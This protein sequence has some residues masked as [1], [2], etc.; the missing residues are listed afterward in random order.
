ME[1]LSLHILD[2]VENGTA[3]GATLVRVEIEEN[4]DED[5]LVIRI[6]D[7]G[8]GMDPEAAQQA[9]D[10][11]VTTRTTRR[12]GMGLPLLRQATEDAEGSFVIRSQ[13]GKGTHVT[14]TFQA[15][16]LDRQP[17]GDLAET[18]VTLILGNPDID[19]V[20][21]HTIDGAKTTLDTREVRE[22]L[23]DVPITD[24]AVLGL[25]RNLLR[26]PPDG[27]ENDG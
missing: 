25:I 18:M 24:P 1:E 27:G 3:A 14:A 2:V 10:P 7:N 16:H 19:F 12:V 23:G 20:Y 6:E 4:S 8:R 5:R 9:V 26:A 13:P 17:L 11:F 15:S 21:E 22:Q